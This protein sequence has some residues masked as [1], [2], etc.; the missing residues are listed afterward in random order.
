M[1][2]STPTDI[3]LEKTQ[4]AIANRQVIRMHYYSPG[5][6]EFTERAIEPLGTVYYGPSWHV[7]AY[8]QLREGYRSFRLDRMS[9]LSVTAETYP[10]RDPRAFVQYLEQQSQT[11]D[12]SL[13][14]IRF[15]PSAV[16]F[17][18]RQRYQHGFVKEEGQPAYVERWFLVAQ[19]DR[20]CR[21]L[22]TYGDAV[23]IV[24]PLRLYDTIQELPEDE[25]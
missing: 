1:T 4:Q 20:F 5:S 16:S 14:K 11:T 22:L 21:W 7:I 10:L 6:G 17:D 25:S 18:Q 12:A 2:S 15:A 13:M 3:H 8:C 9:K 23:T 24:S 19:E